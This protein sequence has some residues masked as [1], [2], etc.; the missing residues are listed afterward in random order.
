MAYT[1]IN[2]HTEHFNTKTWTGNASARS[3]TGI[4]F[5]PDLVNTRARVATAQNYYFD[6]VRLIDNF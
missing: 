6:K 5:A 4:G 3:F 1:T 2:K